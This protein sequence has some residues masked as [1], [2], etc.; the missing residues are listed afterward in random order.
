[1]NGEWNLS[2]IQ[3]GMT[4]ENLQLRSDCLILSPSKLILDLFMLSERQTSLAVN[5]GGVVSVTSY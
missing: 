1:M 4:C 3:V 2:I 5:I